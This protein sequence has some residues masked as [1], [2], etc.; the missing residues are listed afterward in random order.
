[1]GTDP[2]DTPIVRTVTG[3]ADALGLAA[4]AEGVE[5]PAQVAEL[6]EVGCRYAQGFHF[7]RPMPAEDF[8]EVLAGGRRL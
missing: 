8:G 4:V 3:L 1:M 5:S 7:A 2:Q 6:R